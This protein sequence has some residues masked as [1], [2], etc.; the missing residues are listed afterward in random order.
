MLDDNQF[1]TLTLA[2][3]LTRVDVVEQRLLRGAVACLGPAIAAHR[4]LRLLPTS[5]LRCLQATMVD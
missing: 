2:A 1:S 5:L 3:G 4:H